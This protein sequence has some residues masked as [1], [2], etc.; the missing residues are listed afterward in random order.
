MTHVWSLKSIK[1][2]Q[3]GEHNRQRHERKAGKYL[4]LRQTDIDLDSV[5]HDGQTASIAMRRCQVRCSWSCFVTHTNEVP[6]T[7]KPGTFY[8]HLTT[9]TSTSSSASCAFHTCKQ[10]QTAWA[11][12]S[13]D[14]VCTMYSNRL[15]DDGP[16]GITLPLSQ[17]NAKG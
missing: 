2:E 10:R 8:G 15:V 3:K 14:V 17:W 4:I 11:A 5:A 13:T 9:M 6:A 1:A 16:G 12:A 7:H